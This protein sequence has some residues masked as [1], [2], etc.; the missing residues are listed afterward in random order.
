V[1]EHLTQCLQGMYYEALGK[2]GD[3]KEWYESILKEHPDNLPARRRLIAL[4]KSKGNTGTA[5]DALRRHV[6]VFMNDVQAWEELA[7]LYLQV[8]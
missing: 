2:Y 7:E 6:D 5:L 8:F 1:T 4:E 3:A